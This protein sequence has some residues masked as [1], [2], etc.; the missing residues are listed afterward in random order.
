MLYPTQNTSAVLARI[1]SQAQFSSPCN[2]CPQFYGMFVPGFHL[3]AVP[4]FSRAQIFGLNSRDHHCTP[5]PKEQG[6][7][8]R[9]HKY[10][11]LRAVQLSVMTKF[12]QQKNWKWNA[13]LHLPYKHTPNAQLQMPRAC[14]EKMNDLLFHT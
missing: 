1:R 7:V 2:P 6:R 4:S 12:L 10:H 8:Y 9:S 14:I 13:Q 3:S 11:L 5:W